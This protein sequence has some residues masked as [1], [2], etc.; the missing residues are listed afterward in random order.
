[1]KVKTRYSE[2]LYRRHVDSCFRRFQDAKKSA[3]RLRTRWAR[4]GGG[5]TRKR[6]WA[7][8]YTAIEAVAEA[9]REL[10]MATAA[11]LRGSESSKETM[12]WLYLTYEWFS[13]LPAST[14]KAG[15]L[16]AILRSLRGPT[17]LE[18]MAG[19]D[20]ILPTLMEQTKGLLLSTDLA[21]ELMYTT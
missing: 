16:A 5:S 12:Y 19:R 7:S 20:D 13:R 2:R 17:G 15:I 4:T 21:A 1:M 14:E 8:Y 10:Y 9:R 6:R 18:I 11:N 3:S